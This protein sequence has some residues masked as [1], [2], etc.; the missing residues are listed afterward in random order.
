MIVVDVNILVYLLLSV[1]KTELARAAYALDPGWIAPA[2]LSSELINVLSTWSRKG[3]MTTHDCLKAWRTAESLMAGN[4]VEVNME[5]TLE[6]SIRHKVT[7]YDAQYVELARSR[8]LRLL[9]EDGELLRKF[10][11]VAISLADYL[12]V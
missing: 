8:N 1:E 6:L 10:P 2:L 12:K 7:A 11:R 9:T 3:Y 4:L 5:E